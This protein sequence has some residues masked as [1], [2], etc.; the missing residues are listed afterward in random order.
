MM[1]VGYFSAAAGAR[2]SE[3]SGACD[4]KLVTPAP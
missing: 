1:I 3:Q 4:V 2:L